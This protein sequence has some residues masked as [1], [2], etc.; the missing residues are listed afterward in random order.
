[1]AGGLRDGTSSNWRSQLPRAAIQA[2]LVGRPAVT[3]TRILAAIVI[4]GSVLGQDSCKQQSPRRALDLEA[5]DIDASLPSLVRSTHKLIGQSSEGGEL[6]AYWDGDRTKLLVTHLFGEMGR[7]T[8]RYYYRKDTLPFLIVDLSEHYDKP[9]S[10]TVIAREEL[11]LYASGDSLLSW[12]PE[13]TDA[14]VVQVFREHIGT[15]NILR[16]CAMARSPQC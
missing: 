16:S 12:T 1:M 13:T 3:L 7:S 8:T 4:S 5:A 15:A 14:N 10:E 11:R 9:L 6:T 2:R